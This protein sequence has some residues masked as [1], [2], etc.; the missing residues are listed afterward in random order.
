MKYWITQL[1]TGSTKSPY[2]IRLTLSH[3]PKDDAKIFKWILDTFGKF[4][5]LVKMIEYPAYAEIYFK[6]D[7]DA[8]SFLLKWGDSLNDNEEEE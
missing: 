2:A 5:C 4:G 6:D 1:N 8:T 3:K 7:S